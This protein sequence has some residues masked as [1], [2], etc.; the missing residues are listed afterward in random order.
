M[1]CLAH[2]CLLRIG[3]SRLLPCRVFALSYDGS[4]KRAGARALHTFCA[5]LEDGIQL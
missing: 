2:A 1:A 4:V 5:L 3:W